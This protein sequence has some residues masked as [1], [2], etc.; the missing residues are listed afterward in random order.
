MLPSPSFPS[1]PLPLGFSPLQQFSLIMQHTADPQRTK[2]GL[3]AQ[4]PRHHRLWGFP[5]ALGAGGGRQS[6]Q[7]AW[8]ITLSCPLSPPTSLGAG[9]PTG[10]SALTRTTSHLPRPQALDVVTALAPALSH[11][12]PSASPR[13]P[14]YACTPGSYL[15]PHRSLP[16]GLTPVG[17]ALSQAS[18]P[19]RRPPGDTVSGTSCRQ[20]VIHTGICS[21]SQAQDG[22]H[23]LSHKCTPHT[24]QALALQGDTSHYHPWGPLVLEHI[25]H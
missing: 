15:A 21:C 18:S 9:Y 3:P 8:I 5:L 12:L 20:V 24:M 23:N 16:P 10:P 17:A 1:P 13:S 7:P 6:L 11:L 14:F 22:S 2:P 4:G 19:G 25:T